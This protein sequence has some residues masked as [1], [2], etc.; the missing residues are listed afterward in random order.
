MNAV[1]FSL[2]SHFQIFG[3]FS[4]IL[5]YQF[6]ASFYYSQATGSVCSI[7]RGETCFMTQLRVLV[8]QS[9]VQTGSLSSEAV[10]YS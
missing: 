10:E 6:I 2:L 4:D 1:I 8:G 5:Y 9:C 7:E 3:G